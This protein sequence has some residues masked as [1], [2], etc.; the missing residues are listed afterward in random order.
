MILSA[1]VLLCG[2]E[3]LAENIASTEKPV[4]VNV[5]AGTGTLT[6]ENNTG[7]SSTFTVYSITGQVVKS[8]TL[9]SDSVTVSLPQGFYIIK[10]EEN[11]V[12]VVVK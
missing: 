4:A 9:K 10:G 11:T 1:F 5:S 12:K 7:K 8:V 6:I 3:V 2:A